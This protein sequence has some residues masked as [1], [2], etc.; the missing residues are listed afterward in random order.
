[1]K[2]TK[3]VECGFVGWADLPNCKAC[4][5]PLVQH[6]HNLPLAT[7]VH[8][9][10][11]NQWDE[12]ESPRKGLAI[13]ALILGIVNFFTLGILGLGAIVGTIVGWVAMKRAKNDPSRYGGHGQAI[14]GFVL[15]IVT[16]ASLV[17]I[18]I[19][20]A[21]AVPNLLAARRA[22]NEG[23]AIYSLRQISAAQAVYQSNF[24]KYGTLHEL[25][26][27]NLID[28]KLAT[29]TKSGYHFAIELTTDEDNAE[30]FVVTGIPVTYRSTGRRSFYVDETQIIRAADRS[31]GLASEVDEPLNQGPEY[32]GAEPPRRA[33]Y[34][35]QTV[36]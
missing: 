27:Q 5:A 14:A 28:P 15:S 13:F 7:H 18:A 25:A 31:G 1:M 8:S 32:R 4:G 35:P 23:S 9:S 3:C 6:S 20:A 33:D 34:R 29:G 36:Y 24:G 16:F 10:N 2:S 17:P 22:A 12:P 26:A 19:V 21:I 11:Y 30:G